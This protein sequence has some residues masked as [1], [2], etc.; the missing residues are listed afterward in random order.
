MLLPIIVPSSSIPSSRRSFLPLD[1]IM[2]LF[3]PILHQILHLPLDPL[4]PQVVL[5]LPAMVVVMLDT[6]CM[7]V[8][9]SM[10]WCQEDHL[11]EMPITELPFQMVPN[12]LGLEERLLLQHIVDLL[13]KIEPIQFA[14]LPM[15]KKRTQ[16]KITK[17]S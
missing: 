16:T 6:Q 5:P 4:D 8:K 17:I 7:T 1:L 10:S 14:S 3:P 12:F 11:P 15:M 13:H 2:A 9:H